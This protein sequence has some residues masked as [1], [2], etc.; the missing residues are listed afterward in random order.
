MA[1]QK[2]SPKIK[3]LKL[4]EEKGLALIRFSDAITLAPHAFYMEVIKKTDNCLYLRH[5]E[6]NSILKGKATYRV[7]IN[8]Q[9]EWKDYEVEQPE[10]LVSAGSHTL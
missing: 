3:I 1:K 7:A 5:T 9:T 4:N 10:N 6:K 8:Q 2:F